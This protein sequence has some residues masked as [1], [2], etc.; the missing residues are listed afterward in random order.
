ML[1]SLA[2]SALGELGPGRL[3]F[4]S[5]HSLRFPWAL[6]SSQAKWLVGRTLSLL[7]RSLCKGSSLLP[8]LILLILMSS[9]LYLPNFSMTFSPH[10]T[11]SWH[12]LWLLP[13]LGFP[14]SAINSS[15]ALFPTYIPSTF[16]WMDL[17]FDI[18]SPWNHWA[19][20]STRPAVG[21]HSLPKG[22]SQCYPSEDKA[23]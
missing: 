23:R 8:K 12:F 4:S 20:V 22:H 11:F 19:G 3:I 16:V 1:S 5:H 2:P 18:L 15:L 9:V 21:W 14:Y 10:F 13:T 7:L 6:S 17:Y